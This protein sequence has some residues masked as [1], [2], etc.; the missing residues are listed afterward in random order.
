MIVI[1]SHIK[2]RFTS[3]RRVRTRIFDE[4]ISNT[5][6]YVIFKFQFCRF[7][8]THVTFAP[9]GGLDERRRRPI[10]RAHPA[11]RGR[12]ERRRPGPGLHRPG[13]LPQPD[14]VR[15]ADGSAVAR[16]GAH[17]RRRQLLH[18]REGSRGRAAPSGE[19]GHPRRQLVRCDA[20][21]ESAQDG[22]G[23]GV[24]GDNTVPGGGL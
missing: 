21:V 14:D 19:G 4:K 9:V 16:E 15:R 20:R 10:T 23:A 13:H 2:L 11:A 6:Q 1:F 3:L 12:P 17:E 8:E 24:A 18:R 5:I 7:Q 22:A